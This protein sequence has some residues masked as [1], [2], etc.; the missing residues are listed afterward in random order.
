[1]KAKLDGIEGAKLI[2]AKIQ[3]E[4]SAKTTR[5]D[6]PQFERT[7]SVGVTGAGVKPQFTKAEIAAMDDATYA[8]NA[9][10]IFYA[11][12]NGLVQ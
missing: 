12:A 4:E 3:Q 8:K 7:R 6:V 2:W 11:Y 10:A 1:M 9:D 5:T